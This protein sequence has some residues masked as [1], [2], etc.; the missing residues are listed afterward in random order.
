MFTRPDDLGDDDIAAAVRDGWGLRVQAVVYAALGF[1]SHHWHAHDD[2]RRWFV[3][4]DDLE[5]KRRDAAETR[6]DAAR[7]L[8]AAWTAARS[9]RDAGSTFVAA[10]VPTTT[11]ALLQP[12][13]DRYVAALYEYV[14]GETHGWGPYP[15]RA[16][17]FAVV[18]RVV[19]L[20]R[21]GAAAGAT[22]LID[23]FAIP[24][25]DEL[26]ATL[27]DLAGPWGP[28]PYAEPARSLLARHARAVEHAVARYDELVG[29]VARR[30]DRFVLTHGEPHQGNTIVTAQG[31]MLIDWDT[32]LRAPPERDLWTLIDEDESVADYYELHTGVSLDRDALAVYRLWWDLCEVSLYTAECRRAHDDTADTQTAWRGLETYLD[33]TRWIDGV[34]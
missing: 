2:E 20:H 24:R 8:V 30:P 19:E 23:D 22:A 10:P 31:V 28:G 1:G 27:D 7:R 13:G 14:D 17:R 29:V 12:I 9:L 6:D 5:A 25:R 21:C 4:V 18:D 33:P 11:R 26:A 16:E 15:T 3:T 34:E 32:A